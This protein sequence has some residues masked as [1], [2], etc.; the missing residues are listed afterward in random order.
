[1]GAEGETNWTEFD[2]LRSAGKS[3]RE[4]A[5]EMGISYETLRKRLYRRRRR[6]AERVP[7][8]PAGESYEPFPRFTTPNALEDVPLDELLALARANRRVLDRVDPVIAHATISIDTDRPLGIIFTS[9][10]HLGSRYVR[11]EDFEHVL[12]DVLSLDGIKWVSL[13]DDVEG[14]TP[15]FP[16]GSA[17]VEQALANPRVQRRM[18]A[19]VLDKL[20][21]K[22]KLLAG[23]ASQHGGKWTEMKTGD[24]PIKDMYLSRGVPFFDGQALVKLAVGGESYLIALAHE[25]PGGSQWNRNHAQQRAGTFHFPSADVVVSGDKHVGSIQRTTVSPFE[26]DAG[27]RASYV[28]WNVQVGT[29]KTGLDKYAIKTWSRGLLEWPI[30][31]FWPNEHRIEVTHDI[32]VARL[33]I[34]RWH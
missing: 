24:N 11:H 25:F 27:L 32:S 18:L 21:A 19:A 20:A 29:A 17:V 15:G 10:A 3:H 33:L 4:C 9:C 22:G 14:F 1:M 31:I 34:E 12:D 6:E 30:L 5:D 28:R 13:G 7:L 26:F 23:C 8:S 2:A 16:D